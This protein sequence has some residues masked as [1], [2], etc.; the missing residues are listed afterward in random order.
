MPQTQ[1]LK[2]KTIRISDETMNAFRQI[3][4]SIGANQDIALAKLLETYKMQQEKTALPEM[5]KQIEAF[6]DHMSFLTQAY[7]QALTA[8]NDQ[9]DSIS[10]RYQQQIDSQ[11]EQLDTAKQELQSIKSKLT[12][13][14][15][16]VKKSES[17]NQDFQKQIDRLQKDLK[18]QQDTVYSLAALNQSLKENNEMLEKRIS[19]FEKERENFETL[20]EE[21][22]RVKEQLQKSQEELE[23]SKRDAEQT[24]AVLK[25]QAENEKDQLKLHYESELQKE[26]RKQE[27]VQQEEM[28]SIRSNQER[29]EKQYQDRLAELLHL[30]IESRTHADASSG[31]KPESKEP[32]PST[33]KS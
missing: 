1:E 17:K 15:D 31:Q 16:D 8:L 19:D 23:Q 33:K 24:I 3:S 10:T 13:A 4:S 18:T 25:S 21:H 11:K 26:L 5:K 2:P 22:R 14:Q 28:R 29:S 12:A 6:E 7:I 9:E 27:A 20:Q 30:L 32:D